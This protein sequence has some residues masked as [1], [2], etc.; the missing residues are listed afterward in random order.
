MITNDNVLSDK[1]NYDLEQRIE[2]IPGMA[3]KKNKR[4]SCTLRNET[5]IILDSYL[6]PN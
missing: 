5:D 1:R 6:R 2:I 3:H 4:R